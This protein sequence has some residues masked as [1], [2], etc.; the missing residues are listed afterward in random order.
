MNT[1]EAITEEARVAED[2][3]RF[4]AMAAAIRVICIDNQVR[5]QQE[6]LSVSRPPRSAAEI[7]FVGRVPFGLAF[8]E[9]NEATFR[10]PSGHRFVIEHVFVQDCDDQTHLEVNMVTRSRRMFQHLSL[11]TSAEVTSPIVVHGSTENT[12]L[13]RNGVEPSSS[14]V[15]LDA[16]VQMWGYLEPTGDAA[17]W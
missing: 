2:V 15:P 4:A 14:T 10:V 8:T 3:A 12:L 16:Y 7:D 9:G 6:C 13:F 1:S 5:L 17:S 11:A